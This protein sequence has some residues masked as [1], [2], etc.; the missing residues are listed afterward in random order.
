M[1]AIVLTALLSLIT[2]GYV[3]L[4]QLGVGTFDALYD[5]IVL[6]KLPFLSSMTADFAVVIIWQILAFFSLFACMIW[7]FFRSRSSERQDAIML[8][9]VFHL[10]WL[11]TSLVWIAVGALYPFIDTVQ[12]MTK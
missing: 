11:F 5:P 9:A 2:I 3:W 4:I 10:A 7:S 6:G 1:L 8:P 12:V